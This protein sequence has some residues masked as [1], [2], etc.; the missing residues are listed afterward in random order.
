MIG[1]RVLKLK[2]PTGEQDVTIT[3]DDPVGAGT[4]WSCQY[5]ITWPAAPRRYTAH[6]VDALQAVHLAQQMV[7][8]ELYS[9]DFHAR[10]QLQWQK[11]GDGYGFPVPRNIRD[12]LIGADRT[13]DG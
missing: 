10:G 12:L 7:G 6:G 5:Q 3:I 9:S 4:I 13:F 8:A 1:S 2:L 11:P